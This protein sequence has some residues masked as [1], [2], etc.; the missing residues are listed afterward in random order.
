M[1]V[2]F[3]FSQINPV[4][5]ECVGAIITQEAPDL[6]LSLSSAVAPEIGEYERSATALFNAYVGR[7]IEGY[8]E[9]LE[10]T[11]FDAGLKQKV[12]IVQSNGGLVTASQTI[13]V[14]TIESGPA[15]GVVGAAHLARELGQPN[16]IATDVGGTTSKVAVIENG[17]WNYSRETVI[18][19]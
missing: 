12:L 14:L 9:R 6:F 7:V 16:V 11:L 10:Q 2:A 4:H 18:N 19:Q 15:V 13:P 1:A 8:L 17:S 5:E 3:L